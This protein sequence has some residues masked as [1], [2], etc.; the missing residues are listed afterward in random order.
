LVLDALPA[1]ERGKARRRRMPNWTPPMLATLTEDRFSD[2]N[3]IFERKFD[4]VRCLAFVRRSTVR[5]LTR[6]QLSANERYPEIVDSLSGQDP[7]AFIVDGEA[8]AFRGRESSFSMLQTRGRAPATRGRGGVRLF[9]YVF[10]VLHVDG[11]DVT[12]L[13]LLHRK[14]LLQEMLDYRGALRFTTHRTGAGDRYAR[15]AC[16][17][18]WEG[19]IAKLATSPYEQGRSRSWLKLKCVLEQEF[20]IGGYTEPQ[21]SRDVLGALLVGYYRGRD[22]IYAGKVGTGFD[23]ETLAD[24]SVSLSKLERATA[25]FVE[26]KGIPRKAVHW[27]KPTLV[28][29]VGF[30]EW[31][32]DGRLRHSRFLGLRTDKAAR[33]VV[34]EEPTG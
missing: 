12:N 5:L 1:A 28:A 31:T 14:A 19:I 8:V 11:W 6:N 2:P 9:F 25:P 22:L 16:E 20:V 23:D 15:E 26:D 4:G 32:G 10:D 21:G 3:W 7:S 18:G 34:R 33:D 24:L 29:Q 30:A 13:G 17:K 27:V